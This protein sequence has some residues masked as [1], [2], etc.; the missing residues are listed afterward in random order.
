MPDEGRTK[1][2]AILAADA[3]G[4]S[5]AV[6][7]DEA[8]ALTALANSRELIDAEIERHGGRIWFESTE[9][10]GTTFFLTLPLAPPLEKR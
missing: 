1:P 6:A 10:E 8:L 2:A 3:V 4:Y 7:I 5:H 9:G